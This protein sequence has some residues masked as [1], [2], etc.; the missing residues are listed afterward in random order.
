ME[1]QLYA[2]LYGNAYPYAGELDMTQFFPRFGRPK[3]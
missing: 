3:K 2:G 1:N